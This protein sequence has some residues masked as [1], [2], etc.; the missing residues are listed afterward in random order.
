[1]KLDK[2]NIMYNVLEVCIF[3]S[4]TGRRTD[5]NTLDVLIRSEIID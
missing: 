3:Y 4:V 5:Q 1:M 2:N